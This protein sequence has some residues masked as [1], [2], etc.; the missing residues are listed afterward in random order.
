MKKARDFSLFTFGSIKEEEIRKSKKKL[1]SAHLPFP[2]R[3]K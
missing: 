3:I 2:E 1:D